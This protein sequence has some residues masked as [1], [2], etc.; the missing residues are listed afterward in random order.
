MK[1]PRHLFHTIIAVIVLFPAFQASAQESDSLLTH[2]ACEVSISA[3]R[4][5]PALAR[6]KPVHGFLLTSGKKTES[7]NL[8]VSGADL[9]SAISRQIFSRVPGLSI[10]ENDGSGIQVSVASRGLS[11]NRSW[12][13]NVRQ[14]GHDISPDVFGYPEAYYSPPAEAIDRIEIIRGSASLQF[15][16]QFGGLLNYKIKNG[17][18]KEA[19]FYEGRQTLGSFALSDSYH[20]LGG[21]KGKV[22]WYTFYHRR[23]ADG[24]RQN[25]EYLT[26]TAYASLDW[27]ISQ[28]WQL[29]ASFTHSD[30]LSQQPGGLSD[31]EF[32]VNPKQSKRSRNWFGAPWNVAAVN[33]EGSITSNL[34]M[35][36]KAFGIVAERNSVGWL[37]AINVPDTINTALQAYNPRQVDRDAYYSRGLETRFLYGYDFLGRQMKLAAGARYSFSETHRRQQGEGSSGFGYDLEVAE[38]G[39]GKDLEY[40]NENLAFFAENIFQ[41]T[42]AFTITPG[43]RYENIMSTASGYFST[44]AGDMQ[45]QSRK[46][47]VLLF[48]IGSEY[49]FAE[50]NLYANFSQAFRP[51][52][53]SELTPSATSDSIDSNLKDASGFNLDAGYRGNWN[54][55][56]SF[57]V[58]IF[59][60]S[61]DN[62]IGNLPLENGNLRTNI[63]RSFTRGLELYLESDAMKKLLPDS[64]WGYVSVFV[65]ASL[66][67]AKYTRWDNQSV[68]NDPSK[69]INGK[70]LEYVPEQSCKAGIRYSRGRFSAEGQW[71]YVSAVYTDAANTE[72]AGTNAQSGK[73]PSY[74]VLD[75]S[76]KYAMKKALFFQA[77]V[78]N[79][80][81]EHYAT[82]RSGGYPGPG[83][84][85]ANGR[86]V[87]LTVGVRLS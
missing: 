63:G 55:L 40:E 7:I 74:Q 29:S 43:L 57:D 64:R 15:G 10:W 73:I 61:Y 47:N 78:N 87:Y 53:Y 54:G 34:S 39:F 84:L 23:S 33:L 19:V 44:A 72:K 66:M 11:P 24:W 3:E 37:K 38:A 30:Y 28:N 56:L 60:L 52:T 71:T 25:S 65:S 13:F 16:P 17:K 6:L 8:Q 75:A 82:R 49:Q 41:V 80:L 50:T 67:D 2:Q 1:S 26:Q 31:E 42:D 59:T 12:E 14:N 85:P 62:R 5:A 4:N 68:A 58:S 22:S 27:Q 81:D 70:K 83:L 76:V 79:L 9:S 20:A 77:G 21:S 45:E 69:S 46:R 32:E 36:V 18:G 86:S 51:V 48:G 35:Q